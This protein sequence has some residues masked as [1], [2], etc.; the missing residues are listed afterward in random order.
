MQAYVAKFSILVLFIRV[1]YGDESSGNGSGKKLY[2]SERIW[3]RNTE[4]KFYY[5]FVIDVIN[6]YFFRAALQVRKI[7]KEKTAQKDSQTSHKVETICFVGNTLPHCKTDT[8]PNTGCVRHHTSCK[9]E[10]NNKYFLQTWLK[11]R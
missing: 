10:P 3:I 9:P 4:N 7:F 2:G 1:G 11:K 6:I 5:S 8:N